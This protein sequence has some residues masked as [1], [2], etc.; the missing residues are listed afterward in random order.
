[1]VFEDCAKVFGPQKGADPEMVERLTRR[2]HEI[3]DRAPR[4]PRGVPMTG[5]AG[6][7]SGGLW[8]FRGATLRPGA[9][10][11]LDTVGFDERLRRAALVV[12]G[13]G[14]MDEQ[15]LTGKAVA[16]VATRARQ[17]GV[18]LHVVVGTNKLDAMQTRLLD[19]ASVTE[20]TNLEELE[21]AGRRIGAGL[22]EP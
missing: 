12:T 16:E 1:V 8:A 20:A 5:G 6:G 7:L 4:D 3:A 14:A 22:G 19:I 13:E 10:F 21:E 17:G 11:V 18:P 9:A 15:T 2:L